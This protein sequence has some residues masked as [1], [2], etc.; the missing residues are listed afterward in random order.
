MPLT[1]TNVPSASSD[2]V[3]VFN[4]DFFQLFRLARPMKA[5]INEF[6]KVME[7]PI[8]TGETITDHIVFQPNEIELDVFLSSDDFRSVYEQI[9]QPYKNG[10]LVTVQS[11]T[12][13]Y[14]DML[15]Q[16]I[17]H[18]EDPDVY[19]GVIMTIKMKQAFFVTAQFGSLPPSQVKN[20]VQAS[21][22]GLGNQQTK[23]EV[24]PSVLSQIGDAF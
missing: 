8:E 23:D 21:T 13:T 20:P 6:A 12:S 10:D 7:H 18:D 1:D 19:D 9:K 2:L 5:R 22:Q 15:I 16:S 4:A 17:P 24:R 11:R 14:E 3:A